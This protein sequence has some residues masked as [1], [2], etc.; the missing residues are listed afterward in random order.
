VGDDYN[1][2][3]RQNLELVL[4]EIQKLHYTAYRRFR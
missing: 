3:H 2:V 4:D 1:R